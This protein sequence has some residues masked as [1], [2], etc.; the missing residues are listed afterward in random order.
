MLDV[1]A[2]SSGRTYVNATS[3]KLEGQSLVELGSVNTLGG[4]LS[5]LVDEKGLKRT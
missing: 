1:L 4:L 5:V 2:E 3:E